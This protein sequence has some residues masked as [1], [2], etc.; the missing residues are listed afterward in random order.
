MKP[1]RSID[2][3]TGS[4]LKNLAKMSLPI[5][6]SNFMQTFYNLT[7]MW[8]LGKLGESARSSVA[9]AGLAFPI[10]FFLAS[11]GFGFTVAGTAMVSRFKGAKKPEKIKEAIGQYTFILGIFSMIFLLIAA[12]F[13]DDI[14]ILLNVPSEILGLANEYMRII[15][16][17][18]IFMFI[19][20]SYQS[21][22]HGLGDTY[23]PM[24]IQ[25]VSVL[26]NVVLDPVFIFGIGF[27]PRMEAVG[28]GYATLIARIIG[29][30]MAIYSMAKHSPH[31]VP[32]F[33]EIKPN[34]RVLKNMIKLALPASLGQSMT[35]FG[36]VF[37]QGFVN[38][39]GTLVISTF[40]I[41]NRMTSFFMMPAMGVSHGLASII[42]QNLGAKKIDRAK[43]SVLL[44]FITVISI[45]GIGCALVFFFGAELTRFF[46]D[47][48]KVIEV[49][50]RMFKVTSIAAF[51]FSVLFVFMGVFNGSGQ[52]KA[53]MFLNVL[54]L[55][56]IRIP[57]V[58]LLSGSFLKYAWVAE[59]A[60]APILV[61]IAEPLS[62]HP[63]DSL[64]WSMLISNTITSTLSYIIY[65]QGGWL[66]VKVD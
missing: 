43:R 31:L 28:A 60:I 37:L 63:Y 3:T 19:F 36:F 32:T 17:G 64:W 62:A 1:G 9:V 50:Q 54:R 44:A 39:F 26:I 29:A 11:F 21:I 16:T 40:S 35:S 22:S 61:Q 48:P 66:R 25:I 55:W 7:D 59:S 27:I 10:I 30:A 51:I 33:E 46:I 58:Y 49:G 13:I 45:M 20:I 2:L 5:M 24:V 52:T 47:D 56:G 6:L 23:T 57:L 8:W 18:M 12:F 53:T 41:G 34:W 38:S 14:L 65:R 15:M 4:I 42:G